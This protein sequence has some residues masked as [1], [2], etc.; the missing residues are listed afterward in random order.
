[1]L[2]LNF[3][4]FIFNFFYHFFLGVFYY[5]FNFFYSVFD[6]F[7][8]FFYTFFVSKI[9][10][11]NK[12]RV[13][14]NFI[15]LKFLVFYFYFFMPVRLVSLLEI[16]KYGI[17][18]YDD[19]DKGGVYQGIGSYVYGEAPYL[20]IFFMFNDLKKILKELNEDI[21][22]EKTLFIDLGCGVGKPVFFTN[23]FFNT[24]SLGID[25]IQTFIN[26][27]NIIKKFLINLRKVYFLKNDIVYFLDNF[28]YYLKDYFENFEVI[29][30]FIIYIPATA[31]SKTLLNN[32]KLRILKFLSYF[33]NKKIYFIVLTKRLNIES[34]SLIY[35]KDYYFS[36][37]RSTV[38]FYEF[39]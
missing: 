35:K 39:I 16:R 29:E 3:F 12:L 4:A 26:K 5:L 24:F 10:F 6:L 13:Y 22:F 25:N 33:K 28:E 38:Y 2:I 9:N 32:I 7:F 23:I 21:N 15:I 30:Y 27:A 37:F 18:T 34:L 11:V 14:L 1:M 8:L 36:W 17:N 19:G 31:F 20:T